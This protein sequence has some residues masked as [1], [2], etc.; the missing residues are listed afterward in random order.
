MEN[1]NRPLSGLFFVNTEQ[2]Q[3]EHSTLEERMKRF[4]DQFEQPLSVP[5]PTRRQTVESNQSAQQSLPTTQAV[6]Q[7][8]TIQIHQSDK[9]EQRRRMAQSPYPPTSL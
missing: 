9:A 8:R 7:E 3:Q 2:V 6:R 5:K 4:A 1:T